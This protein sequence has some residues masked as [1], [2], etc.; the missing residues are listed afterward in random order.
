M[1]NVTVSLDDET[2][3]RARLRAAEMDTSLSAL[4]REFLNKVGAQETEF[5]RLA[6]EQRELFEQFDRDGIGVDAGA[7][8]PREELYDRDRARR[9]AAEASRD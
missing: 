5:E 1:K 2:Y 6:R 9:D 3:R 7:R 8:L 4:V